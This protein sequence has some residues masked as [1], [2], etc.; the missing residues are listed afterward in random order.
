M[1][2]VSGASSDSDL[3][4]YL[5]TSG[6][7]I[8]NWR[9]RGSVPD[10]Y[11]ERLSNRTGIPVAWVAAQVGSIEDYEAVAHTS[12]EERAPY[13]HRAEDEFVTI[14]HYDARASAGLGVENG[15][16]Q[17]KKKNA[18]RREWWQR[19]VALPTEQCFSMDI[20]G[21]S[22]SPRLTEAHIPIVQRLENEMQGDGIYVFRLDGEVFV[23][24]LERR[25]GRGLIAK[26]HNENY[27]P[28][29]IGDGST[30][31]E[32]KIIGRVIRKMIVE[33]P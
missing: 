30:F 32:F 24:Y 28:W 27:T 11:I 33:L 9:S 19:H 26:S 31:G 14:P 29:D 12:R 4:V 2:R 20:V 13:T 10:A 23:K 7:N 18:F 15:E 25:P 21:D 6:K 16:D 8:S 17:I 5:D 1:K 22:M 3:G